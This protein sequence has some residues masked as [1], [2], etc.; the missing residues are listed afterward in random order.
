MEFTGQGLGALR[1]VKNDKEELMA[2]LGA[3]MLE[4]QKKVAEATETL[5]LRASGE[6]GALSTVAKTASDG[7]EVV[8]KWV[9]EW[10]GYSGDI[11]FELNTDFISMRL[12]SRE[13]LALMQTWQGGGISQE[14]FLDNL[15]RG[16][17]LPQDRTLEEEKALLDSE[18]NSPR[19]LDEK[20]VTPVKRRFELVQDKNGKTTG[21]EEA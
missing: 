9:A 5:K 7:I 13:L 11:K 15:K 8:L 12:D 17:I 16:E 19:M 21:I 18:A 4:D 1:E 14:T 2:R 6:N 3:R 10:S 20:D